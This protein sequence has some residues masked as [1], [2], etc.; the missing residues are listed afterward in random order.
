MIRMFVLQVFLLS[1]SINAHADV[2]K[3]RLDQEKK[4]EGI[5]SSKESNRIAIEGDRITEVIGLGEEFALESEETKGQIFIKALGTKKSAIFTVMTEKGRTQDF[6]LMVKEKV[7]GQVIILKDDSFLGNEKILGSKNIRHDEVVSV[8]K[9]MLNV[10]YEFNQ[11]SFVSGVFELT[12][13]S[14]KKLGKYKVEVWLVKNI[15]GGDLE[16]TEKQ[17]FDKANI[18]AIAL[19][20]RILGQGG[21]TKMY[22]VLSD[23]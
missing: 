19:E 22:R 5:I 3:Y 21:T 16:I 17:F 11:S 10:S 15:S 9:Q 1:F 13:L 7:E 4:V 8:I 12:P 20:K 14:Q 6:K 23:A 18:S 2:Q